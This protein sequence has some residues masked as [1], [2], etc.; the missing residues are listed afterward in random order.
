MSNELIK[1]LG[2]IYKMVK[3]E[4][5][6]CVYFSSD[7]LKVGCGRVYSHDKARTLVSKIGDKLGYSIIYLLCDR[8]SCLINNE[9]HQLKKGT[10]IVLRPEEKLELYVNEDFARFKSNVTLDGA[11]VHFITVDIISDLLFDGDTNV[12]SFMRA[13]S[14][15]RL[16][17]ANFYTDADFYPQNIME[18]FS[19]LLTD[20][21]DNNLGL[22][23]F[24][25]V[26]SLMITQIN[27]AFDRH[28]NYVPTKYSDEYEVKVYDYIER[29]YNKDISI[30][31]IS[32]KFFISKVYINKITNRFYGMN[33]SDT[34]RS[35]RMWKSI[36]LMQT[37]G[38]DF[39]TISAM[40]GY[41]NYSSFFR[42]FT[43]F[44]GITPTQKYEQIKSIVENESKK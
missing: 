30:K 37:T 8:F 13:F 11:N 25:S 29:N 32:E 4:A 28:N 35:M 31:S 3:N 40:C 36:L 1:L 27:M 20:Y 24:K 2:V 12:E 15:R 17:T 16:Y 6:S 5:S 22:F 18:S 33:F 43:D 38:A 23:Q 42:S 7:M 19:M 9:L 10:L 41:K 34:V 44:F 21:I 26:V 39:K 14:E